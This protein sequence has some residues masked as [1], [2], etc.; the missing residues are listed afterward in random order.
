MLRLASRDPEAAPIIDHGYL[1]DPDDHDLAVLLDGVDLA[2]TLARQA[3]LAGL[4]G[5]ETGPGPEML[6]RAELQAYIRANGVHYYHPVGTC[7]MGPA[8]DSLAVVDARGHV[9]GL[10]GLIVADASIMPVIPRANTNIPC[11]VIGEKIAALLL[12]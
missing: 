11:A 5:A 6:D 7:K 12:E 8:D 3:P 10:D 2:R 4:I 1:T 9:H